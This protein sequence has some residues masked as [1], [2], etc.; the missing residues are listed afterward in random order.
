[1][2]FLTP[3]DM[4]QSLSYKEYEYPIYLPFIINFRQ[5]FGERQINI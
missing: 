3:Q 5:I 1:M 2:T 4:K